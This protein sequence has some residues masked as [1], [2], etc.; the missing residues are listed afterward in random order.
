MWAKNRRNLRK[1]KVGWDVGPDYEIIRPLG[2]ESQASV[3]KAIKVATGETFAI[4]RVSG[5]FN[6][7]VACK[8]FLREISIMRRMDHQIGRASCRGV[9]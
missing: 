6:D 1:V 8:S 5:I 4:K 3:C 2:A 7:P 9:G